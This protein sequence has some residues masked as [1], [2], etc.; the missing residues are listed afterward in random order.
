MQLKVESPLCLSS[1]EVKHPTE[2]SSTRNS[3]NFQEMLTVCPTLCHSRQAAASKDN[4]AC[5]P[6]ITSPNH[7]W[8]LQVATTDFD[9]ITGCRNGASSK[10]WL[11]PGYESLNLFIK[12]FKIIEEIYNRKILD[13]DYKMWEFLGW[14]DCIFYTANPSIDISWT[15]SPC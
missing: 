15:L 6:D 11:R 4:T 12:V 10:P 8:V 9:Y 7:N 2:Y 1:Q 13:T 14:R 3:R 5:S